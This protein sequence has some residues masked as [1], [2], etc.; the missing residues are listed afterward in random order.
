MSGLSHVVNN[1]VMN[2]QSDVIVDT[3]LTTDYL[4]FY[5]MSVMNG[6]I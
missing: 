4:S 6:L 2:N 3:M 1:E 5:L